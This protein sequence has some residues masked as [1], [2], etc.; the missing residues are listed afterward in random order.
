MLILPEFGVLVTNVTV[1]WMQEFDRRT[2]A[3]ALLS[4]AVELKRSH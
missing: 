3:W 2:E 1:L 4:L